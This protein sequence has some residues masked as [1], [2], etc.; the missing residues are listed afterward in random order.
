M[1]S[2]RALNRRTFLAS[3][4]AAAAVATGGLPMVAAPARAA[5]G[6]GRAPALPDIDVR[7]AAR[8]DPSEATL[9]EA[10]VL[11]RR[12]KL[13]AV[14]L[15]QAHLERI[16][17]FDS[18]YQAYAEVTGD[19]ALAAARK[20]DRGE[21]PA[22]PL[23]G[24][25]LC[26]KDNY[27]TAGVP[28]RCNSYVFEDFVP[29]ADATA[30]ARL[31]GAGGIVLGKGQMG[32]LATTRA[33]RPNG[34]VTTV[35]AWTPDDPSVDPGGSSTG[36]ACA[37]AARLAVSSIGTQTGGSIVLPSN[38]QNLT[39]LKPTMGRVSI[40]GVIPLSFTRDHAGPLA[41]DAMDAALMLT[42]MAGPDAADPRT[43]GLPDVPDLVRAATPVRGR[44]GAVRMRRA[45]RIGVPADFLSGSA[46]A[47]RQAFL[48]R[49]DAIAGVTLVDVAY[50]ADWSLL[51]GDFNAARLSERTEPFRHWLRE[52]PAKFGVSLLSWLQGL[53]ISGDEW[54]T[55]Q[56]AKTHLLREVLDTVMAR[57]DV[58]LQTGPVP[59]D[60]LGLPEIAFPVGFSA[61][62]VPAGV[63]LGG[64]PYEED[65]LLEVAA[66]YQAVTDWHTRRPADPAAF[67][68]RTARAS[69]R[70]SAEEAAAQSA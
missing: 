41:R 43:L 21:G 6:S 20:A 58:L 70:L 44:G 18:T 12:G 9:A 57:C 25:P 61:A 46:K 65:R 30:V 62:G 49:L 59:F 69:V 38:Q 66:A 51:T 42:V 28:T 16:E 31:K 39:G 47:L 4:A 14:E 8:T 23:R 40:H 36:P 50:P 35:N 60:I 2:R 53:M 26:I 3:S 13:T 56:R 48:D 5:T 55:A 32:P 27:F 1:N 67:K 29:D 17:S 7:D 19:S 68:A 64:Q 63:I 34:T 45:T 33:T 54:I 10:A 24:I 15:V 37:V 22:G 11:M 52:D